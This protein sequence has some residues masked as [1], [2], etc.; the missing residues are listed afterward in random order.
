MKLDIE[1]IINTL[2]NWLGIGSE[3]V[4][5]RVYLRGQLPPVLLVILIG[6]AAAFAWLV[7]RREAA[8]SRWRRLGLATLRTIVY[9]LILVILFQPAVS[10]ERRLPVRRIIV[11]MVDRSKSMTNEDPRS[12]AEHLA[13]AA[14]A[15]NKVKF[16][17]PSQQAALARARRAMQDSA[18]ALKGAHFPDALEAQRRAEEALDSAL[19][20]SDTAGQG[21]DKG[22]QP[23]V[24]QF[25][26]GVGNIASRQKR[27]REE[28]E[29]QDSLDGVKRSQDQEGILLYLDKTVTDLCEVP[30][31]VPAA[32]RNEVA[33]VSRMKMAHGLLAHPEL[34]LLERISKDFVL[35]GYTF[36]EKV[37]A[38][39]G[40]GEALVKSFLSVEADANLT[41]GAEAIEEVAASLGA[42]P[43]DFM[44]ILTDGGFNGGRN[45]REVAAKMKEKGIRLLIVPLG[46]E[47]P[48]DVGIRSLIVQDAFFPK[49]RVTARVQVFSHGYRDVPA[50]VRL[51]LDG[52]ELAKVQVKLTDEPII[53]EIPFEVPEKKG[54]KAALQATISE[55]PEEI[56]TANNRTP[57]PPRQVTI[58]DKKIKVL[59]V[60]GKPRWEY[61]YLRTVLLR[62]QRLD[63]KF[64]M[65]EGDP[66]L[67]AASPQYL[68]NYPERP[69]EAFGFDLVII[70]DVPAYY[71]GRPKLAQIV[72]IVSSRGGSLLMLAGDQHAPASYV[73]T[74][75]AEVLPVLITTER[76][77]APAT[78]HPVAT[79]AGRRSL[80]ML[81][82]PAAV[83]DSIWSLV[84]PLYRIPRLKGTK[85]AANVLVELPPI[86]EGAEPYPLVAWQYAGTGKVMYV[87]TDQLWRL[88][89]MRGDRYHA[90][91]WGQAIRFLAMSRLLGENSRIRLEADRT[92][93]HAGEKVQILANVLNESFQPSN[94]KEYRV[95]LDRISIDEKSPAGSKAAESPV[96]HTDEIA[97]KPVPGK[98][99][100]YQ[101]A[102]TLQDQA[103]YTLRTDK[104]DAKFSNTVSLVVL[105]SNLEMQEPAVQAAL[106]QEMADDS[107]GKCF[108]ISE[109]PALLEY[110]EGKVQTIP[111]P[112]T[113][114]L[115]DI[116]PVYVLLV[117][118]AGAEWLLRRRSHL[119]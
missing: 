17:L 86:K 42:Q 18:R 105:A 48:K 76:D 21:A 41:R 47:A 12:R 104:G 16:V 90:R 110:L 9:G 3:Y 115:W 2:R 67:A 106:L 102:F 43:V 55:L 112:K 75:I 111:D 63:V 45:P 91:F 84:H 101:G 35:K 23:G 64:L 113:M 79:E 116:W 14:L 83:N 81:E 88:R 54:P 71:F 78:A 40:E 68:S 69:E 56:S 73:N 53:V 58:I 74:A 107:N 6:V 11:A 13:D 25:L 5:K 7:Y 96:M 15:L 20:G 77:E 36:G 70:G 4:I 97:L 80:A 28:C 89:F 30:I 92:E 33:K 10:I 51:L 32:D 117:V 22:A 50:E 99:G 100:L 108:R 66:T 114:D 46:L 19:T 57:D 60:E 87:G 72:E 31:A 109:L 61:R 93:L 8:L 24:A 52:A 98:P 1:T 85:P 37:E 29:K 44:L 38:V 94:D 118:C 59:Y 39:G 119:V 103:H 34:R 49:D 26:A 27:L 62:D 95:Y 65:T 82:L